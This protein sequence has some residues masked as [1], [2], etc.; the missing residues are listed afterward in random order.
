MR[1]RNDDEIRRKN[2]EYLMKVIPSS[3]STV[4]GKHYQQWTWFNHVPRF[5]LLLKNVISL[6]LD[7]FWTNYPSHS[8]ILIQFVLLTPTEFNTYTLSLVSF[9]SHSSNK[10]QIVTSLKLSQPTIKHLLQYRWLT[11][12]SNKS[13]S[14]SLEHSSFFFYEDLKNKVSDVSKCNKI[15]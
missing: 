14:Q 3:S 9:H 13:S 12:S 11:M 10:V 5:L 1:E 15:C 6:L 8:M 7:D 2:E 4:F